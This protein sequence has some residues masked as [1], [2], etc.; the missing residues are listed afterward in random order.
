MTPRFANTLACCAFPIRSLLPVLPELRLRRPVASRSDL[1]SSVTCI[2]VVRL[3]LHVASQ[4]FISS[5]L[6]SFP[7][8]ARKAAQKKAQASPL[9]NYSIATSGRFPGTTQGALQQRI[10]DLGGTI[11]SK[12]TSDTNILIATDKDFEAKSTKVA[13]AIA[14]DVP[15]V[16]I[17]WLEE[18]ETSN[19]KADE[20]Q[21][22][23]GSSSAS[24]VA[25]AAAP[26]VVKGKKRAATSS[27]SPAPSQDASQSK[28]RKTLEE[29]AKND[30]V[31]VGDGHNAK[32][33]KI[34][35]PVDEYCPSSNYEVYI[36][37]DGLIWDASLNQTNAS[38]NNNKF[39]KV[40]VRI[41]NR[42]TILTD[43]WSAATKPER[44]ALPNMDTMGA[45]RRE[46]S[47]RH[48]RKWLSVRCDE[49]L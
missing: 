41:F 49:E 6:H 38:A 11:A 29:K 1:T 12:V 34:V 13:A 20:K 37:D 7:T 33:K 16:S 9:D 15:I 4:L 35:V 40:Q 26:A 24:P 22:P 30:K 28:K 19:N 3:H 10:T 45:C 21:Y 47:E 36:D 46:R 31:K 5:Q 42:L 25:S 2:R 18:T 48:A 44:R 32:S 14:S 8:M 17:D 43:I 27:A 23:L 39:Y